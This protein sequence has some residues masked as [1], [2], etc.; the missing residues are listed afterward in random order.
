MEDDEDKEFDEEEA[1]SE[2]AG[3]ELS[4]LTRIYGSE[5]LKR[6]MTGIRESLARP[7][8][9]PNTPEHAEVTSPL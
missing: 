9:A 4:Q 8:P 5:K 3:K 6:H 7:D 2:V 1:G